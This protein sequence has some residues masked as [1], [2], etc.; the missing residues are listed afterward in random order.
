MNLPQ[1]VRQA[2]RRRAKLAIGHLP[3]VIDDRN[4]V[5]PFGGGAIQDGEQIHDV[6][7]VNQNHG[8]MET[9]R[10]RLAESAT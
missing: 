6:L 8:G 2:L 5:W 10:C 9:D 1:F 3:P 7:T 4:G